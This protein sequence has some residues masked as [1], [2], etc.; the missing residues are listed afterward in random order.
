MVFI[1]PSIVQ[2]GE[3]KTELRFPYE[4]KIVDAYA[5]CGVT[6]LTR[7]VIQIE[8][9]TEGDY[10]TTPIWNS[11]FSQDIVIDPNH[12][13]NKTSATPYNVGATYT[14]VA[15]NDHFRL[16]ITEVGT[17]VKDITVELVVEVYIEEPL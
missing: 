10:N 15:P 2:V 1:V 7:T 16:N 11:I 8:K 6:G 5:T 12:K 14:N 9:C 13:S 4:G 17:G 3:V